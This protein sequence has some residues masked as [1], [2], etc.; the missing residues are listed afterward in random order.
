LIIR[1]G[2]ENIE[3]AAQAKHRGLVRNAQFEEDG[4]L[5]FRARLLPFWCG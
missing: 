4:L 3:N 5:V 1:G 2:E